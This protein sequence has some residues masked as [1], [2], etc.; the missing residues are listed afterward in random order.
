MI[1]LLV[2]F[3]L[4]SIAFAGWEYSQGERAMV[5]LRLVRQ[6]TYLV[7]CLY[8]FFLAGAYF[9]ILY[10]LP[11]YFQSIDDVSPIESGVR[12]LPLILAVMVATIVSG[13]SITATGLAT[14][15]E[16][17]GTTIATIAAGLIYTLDIGTSSGKWIGYQIL[18]GLG[19]GGAFQ[20]PIIIAQ[21]TATPADLAEVTAIV[22]C[23]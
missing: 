7:C 17:G 4:L 23:K 8:T 3:V 6:R 20:I 18:A 11:I 15:L 12:N 14:P 21:A 19:Y 9:V 16:V 5:P 22:L 1:G 10:Y 13:G 2:G